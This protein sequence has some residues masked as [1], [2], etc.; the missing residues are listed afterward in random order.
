MPVPGKEAQ[1]MKQLEISGCEPVR[2]KIKGF[3][4]ILDSK[5][6]LERIYHFVKLIYIV[7]AEKKAD[8]RG[9][10]DIQGSL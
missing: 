7:R 8:E 2:T 10:R 5:E 1:S 6:D 4:D 9:K 3:L